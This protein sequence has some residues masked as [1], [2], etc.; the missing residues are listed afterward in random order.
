M[1]STNT[2]SDNCRIINNNNISSSIIQHVMDP[3]RYQNCSPC[4]N[5]FGLVGGNAVSSNKDLI[6]VENHM[7]GLTNKRGEC[8]SR[9]QMNI[10]PNQDLLHLKS[11]QHASYRPIPLP[12][13]FQKPS[14]KC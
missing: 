12:E 6:T 5:E 3:S 1:T 7:L 9:D 8:S 11:C 14:C 4:R 13:P 10:K 2:K